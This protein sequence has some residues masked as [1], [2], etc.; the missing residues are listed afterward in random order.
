M[1][2]WESGDR[3]ATPTRLSLWQLPW[4]N[5]TYP[6]GPFPQTFRVPW[7]ESPHLMV[8]LHSQTQPDLYYGQRKPLYYLED[9]SGCLSQ[10]A[11]KLSKLHRIFLIP[12]IISSNEKEQWQG[13]REIRFP[14]KPFLK[15]HRYRWSLQIITAR[16]PI[17]LRQGAKLSQTNSNINLS[18]LLLSPPIISS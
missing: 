13:V 11:K 15:A 16:S 3:R 12:E 17:K 8:L 10:H 18:F 14:N 4:L 9:T 5:S 6:M 7:G 1:I 2:H